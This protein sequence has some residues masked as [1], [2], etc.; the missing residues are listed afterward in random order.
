MSATTKNML[1]EL[2]KR[3]LRPLRRRV[4]IKVC[5][6]KIKRLTS[7]LTPA[8]AVDFALRDRAISAQQV[9]WEI[10]QFAKLVAESKPKTIVEIG[11]SR[12]GT[13]FVLCRLAPPLS[14]IVSVDM[15]G[16]GFGEAYN[17]RH[18][19]LFKL[20]PSEGQKLHI[21]TADSH[22][23]ETRDRVNA[24]L[25]GTQVDLLFI[26]GDHSYEGVKKDF[27][28]FSPL[29]S[30]SG[31]IVFHDIAEHTKFAGCHVKPFW[32]EVKR[33][34]RHQEFIEDPSQGWAGIGVL[35]KAAQ[36]I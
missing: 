22:I 20:F 19:E 30:P 10:S 34:Y 28:M 14:T 26:D 7:R 8:E 33:N 15:P 3:E 6:Q 29:V 2:V 16:A 12:G 18:V 24:L 4:D 21:V 11:T 17:D 13:L 31:L 23:P 1:T 9:P 25:G 27:E 36:G 35:W 32:D 5:G